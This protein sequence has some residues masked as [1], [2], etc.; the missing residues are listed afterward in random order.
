MRFSI[1]SLLGM[2]LFFG[3][4]FPLWIEWDRHRSLQGELEPLRT[5]VARL[6]SSVRPFKDSWPELSR[7]L[8]AEQQSLR[9][10]A[11][12]LEERFGP[13]PGLFGVPV[14]NPSDVVVEYRLPAMSQKMGGVFQQS[15]FDVVV[16]PDRNVW[17]R[18]AVAPKTGFGF[19]KEDPAAI[20][21]GS[22]LADS[23]YQVLLPQGRHQITATSGMNSSLL[24]LNGERLFEVPIAE[25]QAYHSTRQRIGST[26]VVKPGGSLPWLLDAAT[27]MQRRP[28]IRQAYS[29]WLSEE[30]LPVD[31]FPGAT[32]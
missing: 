8:Q 1:R 21:S 27:V 22:A 10:V 2:L 16:P 12:K 23:L 5:S 11:L 30:R 18:C 32:P 28:P 17:L 3:L 7:H 13:A 19:G 15:R 24:E 31:P 14:S 25:G 29:I 4:C 26:D 20:R 9:D 6:E